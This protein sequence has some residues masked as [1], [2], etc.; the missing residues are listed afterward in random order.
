MPDNELRQIV[1]DIQH[2]THFTLGQVA[3][4]VGYSRDYFTDQVNKG[5]NKRLLKILKEY[6]KDLKSNKIKHFR[7]E[8]D[9][10]ATKQEDDI[11]VSLK[12]I[13][14]TQ[15]FLKAL[16]IENQNRT[17]E[18]ISGLAEFRNLLKK[19]EGRAKPKG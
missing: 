1:D 3:E 14:E 6:H 19:M 9:C 7:T 17:A 15:D 2:W 10:V 12:T 18:V 16:A 8:P 4:Q 11:M 13:L 5:V